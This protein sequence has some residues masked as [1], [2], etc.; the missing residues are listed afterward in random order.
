MM[1]L[2]NRFA[3]LTANVMLFLVG[4]APVGPNYKRPSAS[5]PVSFKEPLP[6]GW[7]QAEPGGA[8]VNGRWW[9]IY[10]DAALNALEQQVSI[11][12]QNVLQAEAQYREARAVARE[13]RSALFPTAGVGIG[14][15]AT[16]AGGAAS[17]AAGANGSSNPGIRTAYNLP[18]NVA[19]EP[20]LWGSIR[21]NIT[22][23]IAA[24]QATEA[25][26]ENAR[27]LFRAELAQDY[28][29]LHG[30]DGDAD[31]LQ[32]T[33]DSYNE[34]L[35]LTKN[36]YAAGVASDLDVAQAESQLYS[37]QSALI[38]L[39]VQRAQLE[40]AIAI[41]TGKSPSELSIPPAPLIMP[42]PPVPIG[43]PSDL[44]ER[45]PDIASA[46]RRV[47]AANEQIGIAMAAF[48]P[49]LTLSAGA[50]LNSSSLAKW[51]SWP[52][53]FWSVGPQLSETLFD[54][55][56]RRAIVAQQQAAYDS[57]VAG[58][59]QSVLTALQQ[60]EDNLA[61]LGVLS[62]ENDKLQQTIQSADRALNISSAQYR[63]GTTSYL[64]VIT[65]QATLLSSERSA[66][67]LLARRLTASV[68]L[69][70]ALGGGWDAS[71]LPTRQDVLAV[72]TT[73]T[74]R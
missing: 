41:L 46:E 48:Y 13:A 73:S 12:N 56:R 49:V 24:A 25:D 54:A 3:I 35:T 57:T 8:F 14:I 31:L 11:S 50:G 19:W 44:L 60:V 39:G 9:E 59:R 61:A 66:V 21:R 38:D 32:R 58:Y 68:L 17:N 42:P 55:G 15:T 43:L 1:L 34:Y 67:Q 10:N 33:S 5:V 71:R 64:T 45:R 47:A 72:G 62:D 26:L 7:K 23:N 29:Q 22:G 18:F 40:H 69:I 36:R 4:C 20:D 2:R 37:T 70:E 27:L 30:I 53:R 16:G 74:S 51:F 6:A 28:F 63:A 52:S 65:S